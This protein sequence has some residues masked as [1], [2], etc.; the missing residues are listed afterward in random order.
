[1]PMLEAHAI[2]PSNETARAVPPAS[3][4][5]LGN[6]LERWIIAWISKRLNVTASTIEP[7]Q[8]VLQLGLDSLVAIQFT[9]DLETYLGRS[10]G[11]DQLWE[12]PTIAALAAS[13]GSSPAVASPAVEPEP[14]ASEPA[15]A[16]V[17][18]PSDLALSLF[19]FSSSDD[20]SGDDKYRL[21]REA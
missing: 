21:V 14:R 1:A 3:T 15:P 8:S 16:P 12:H 19:F 6:G 20:A 9:M 17:A 10:V 7:S 2:V 5:E 11:V 13:L 4:K 18:A